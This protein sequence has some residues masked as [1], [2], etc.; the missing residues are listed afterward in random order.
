VLRKNGAGTVGNNNF[1]VHIYLSAGGVIDWTAGDFNMGGVQSELLLNY[2]GLNIAAGATFHISDPAW[3]VDWLTGGG[4]VNNA[5]NNTTPTLTVGVAGTANNPTYGVI[6][7]TATFSGVIGYSETYNTVSV[8]SM[9]LVK[10]GAGTQI[11]AGTNGY[12]LATTISGGT[13]KIG[14]AGLLGGGGYPGAITNNAAFIYNSSAAQTLSGVISGPGT[15]TQGGPG[16]LTLSGANNYSGVTTVMAGKLVISSAQTGTGAINVNDGAALGV[17]ISGA[18]QLSPAIL[19]EGSSAGPMTNEFTGLISTTVAPVNVGT[20]TLK[21]TT[22]INVVSGTFAAGQ[23]YPLISYATISGAGNFVLGALPAGVSATVVTNNNTIALNVSATPAFVW[24]GN[25]NGTWDITTTANWKTNGVAAKYLDGSRAVQ[26]DDTASTFA[27]SNAATVSPAGIVVN[28][29]AHAYTLGGSAIGGSGALVKSGANA[30]TLASTANT[31]SGP[32]TVQGGTLILSNFPVSGNGGTAVAGAA[33]NLS[34]GATLTVNYA[35]GV[36]KALSSLTG[37]GTFN[38]VGAGTYDPIYCGGT[39]QVLAMSSGGLWHVV[40]G[41]CRLGYGY[42]ANWSNNLGGLTIDSGASMDLWDTTTSGIRFDALNGAGTLTD[43]NGSGNTLWL[44]VAGG[45]GTF[46]GVIL[47]GSHGITLIKT[48]TGTQVLAGTNTYT[49]TTTISNGTLLVSGSLAAGSAVTVQTN[50]TLGGTGT[51]AGAVTVN[52]VMVPGPGLGTLN[53]GAET[54]NG[55]GSYVCNLG[56]TNAGGGDLLNITGAL[57]VAA[58]SGSPFTVKLVSLGAGN[59]PGA[60]TNF[61]KY[62]N[63]AWTVATASGGVAN[64]ATNKVVLDASAFVNDFSGGTFGLAVAGNSLV[65]NYKAAPLVWPRFTGTASAGTAGMQL[66]ATGGVGQAYVLFGTTN[67]APANWLPL[68]TNTAGT[69]GAVQFADPQATN[70]PQRF[71]RI[72]SP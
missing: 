70:Y 52:G 38:L 65:L 15:L 61:Y 51:V 16:T 1:A 30:L 66:T 53:T 27:V 54:W 35:S 34:S 29:A 56:S 22:V 72:T 32:I 45:S 55:G 13:L 11:L 21:G 59:V 46:T 17:T 26:F 64:F 43:N 36:T 25:V 10:V 71:Y 18:S 4:E 6:N 41:N 3:Q 33:I 20:L 44:G 68:A 37:G 60:V 31:F 28:N 23:S 69:N 2:G 67:L 14:G 58:T 9:S 62:T 7:N 63:C 42:A 57:T 24:V 47:Q 50:G 49:G 12:T 8:S 19:A 40:S 48:G 5:Y 39:V